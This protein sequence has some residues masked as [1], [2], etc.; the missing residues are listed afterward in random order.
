MPAVLLL[1]E[2]TSG[3]DS[4]GSRSVMTGIRSSLPMAT[5]V[6]ATHDAQVA[7]FADMHIDLSTPMLPPKA[8]AV[9]T[10]AQGAVPG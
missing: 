1:D 5:I 10:R 7:A 3:L 9:G 2:P 4:A 6:V 8:P